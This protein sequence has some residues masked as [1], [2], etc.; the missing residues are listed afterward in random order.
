MITLK[1][2]P[3]KTFHTSEEAMKELILNKK[4]IIEKKKSAIKYAD[5]IQYFGTI[6][7]EKKEVVKADAVP[8]LIDTS[9]I[10]VV[11]VSNAC[12]YFDSHSD[13]SIS[14]S[15]N[16]TS[17]NTT[18]GLHLQEH[19][20]RFDKLISDDVAFKV[21]LKTWKELGFNYEGSTDCLMMYSEVEK[22]TNPFM[23]G[24]Y[25]KGKVKNHSAGLRYVTIEMAVNS[26][27]DW[28]KDEK[29][30]WDKYYPSIVNKD[31]VDDY[32]YF[33]AV[34]EQKI[35][36]NSAVLKGSNPATPTISV[37]PVTD[38]STKQDP[39]IATPTSVRKK[40]NVFI[41]I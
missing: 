8:N 20:M 6:E 31:D 9:N 25:V 13:V 5:A 34:T 28:A 40:L 21:E 39:V 22:E 2:F 30:I 37:E 17:K 12:N 27:A 16:R 32:G 7:N 24:K 3:D 1:E 11:A 41:K 36:E 33:F 29:E 15:W 4:F 10:K 19:Q 38:T 26:A 35:I 18:N 23:F 14:G